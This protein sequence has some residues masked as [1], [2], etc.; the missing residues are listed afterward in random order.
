MKI[1][2]KER[3]FMLT[4]GASAEIADLCPD[5]DLAKLPKLLEGRYSAITKAT[6]K[7]IAA[8]NK[9]YED[10]RAFEAEGYEAD[11]LT[12]AEIMTLSPAELKELQDEALAAF[13]ADKQP[14]VEVKPAKKGK[15]PA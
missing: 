10:A 13:V 3:K 4:V 14:T 9:G 12:V 2:G 7:I 8:L 11:P 5:G 6:A 15:A 1:H